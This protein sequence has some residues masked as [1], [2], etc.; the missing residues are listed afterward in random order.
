MSR[1]K[2]YHD[3]TDCLDF[4]TDQEWEQHCDIM[5]EQFQFKY[6]MLA[7]KLMY[8]DYLRNITS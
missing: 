6:G 3:T 8:H 4:M 7:G 5:L 2:Q 1:T